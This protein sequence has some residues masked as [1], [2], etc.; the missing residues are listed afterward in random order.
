M[1]DLNRFLLQQ[2]VVS[3]L[4]ISHFLDSMKINQFDTLKTHPD[5]SCIYNFYAAENLILRK[6]ADFLYHSAGYR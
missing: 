2:D 6:L 1:A 4:I 5:P 3:S